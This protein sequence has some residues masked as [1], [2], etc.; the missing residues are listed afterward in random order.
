MKSARGRS[1]VCDLGSWVLE[2]SRGS[3]K[4]VAVTV[5]ASGAFMPYQAS[6]SGFGLQT[7]GLAPPTYNF[8][9]TYTAET[10]SALESF[11]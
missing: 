6:A 10:C 11:F 4:G 8:T 5:L 7:F 9:A 2:N 3:F 1:V